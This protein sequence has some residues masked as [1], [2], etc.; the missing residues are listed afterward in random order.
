MG[1]GHGAAGKAQHVG[2]RVEVF[3]KI[4]LGFANFLF[5]AG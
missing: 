2:P 5:G 3:W 4:F 1:K